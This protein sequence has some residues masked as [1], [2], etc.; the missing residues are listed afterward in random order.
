MHLREGAMRKVPGSNH[1]RARFSRPALSPHSSQWATGVKL[2][3]KCRN[4]PPYL[5]TSLARIVPL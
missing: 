3:V 4:W 1:D 2:G 5:V